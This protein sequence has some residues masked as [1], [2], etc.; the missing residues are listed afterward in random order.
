MLVGLDVNGPNDLQAGISRWFKA[1][2]VSTVFPNLNVRAV[3]QSATDEAWAY[4]KS[5]TGASGVV[6]SWERGVNFT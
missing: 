5:T 2:P 1:A 3:V 4:I 6:V